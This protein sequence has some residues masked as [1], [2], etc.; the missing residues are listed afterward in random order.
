MRGLSSVSNNQTAALPLLFPTNTLS[1]AREQIQQLDKVIEL[2]N[3]K[4]KPEK[5]KLYTSVT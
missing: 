2:E 1:G 3:K 5:L 4:N